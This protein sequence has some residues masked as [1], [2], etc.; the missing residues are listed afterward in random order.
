MLVIRRLLLPARLTLL[1]RNWQADGPRNRFAD[2]I[3]PRH[4][5]VCIQSVRCSLLWEEAREM[6]TRWSLDVTFVEAFWRICQ[7]SLE[8]DAGTCP[9]RADWTVDIERK[10]CNNTRASTRLENN[11]IWKWKRKH[12]RVRDASLNGVYRRTQCRTKRCD[13]YSSSADGKNKWC[14][15]HFRMFTIDQGLNLLLHQKNQRGL[16][17]TI[18]WLKWRALNREFIVYACF[19]FSAWSYSGINN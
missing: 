18:L 4:T 16:Q 19:W 5:Q 14:E 6:Y 11:G 7:S 13:V 17:F 3:N 12:K 10:E 1:I 15:P 2:G 9:S 8:T